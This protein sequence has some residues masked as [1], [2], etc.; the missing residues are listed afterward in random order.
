MRATSGAEALELL[1]ALAAAR[2]AGR[3]RRLRPADAGHDRHRA[4]RRRARRRAGREAAAAHGVRRHRR[5]DLGDQRHR[6]RLLPAQ[7]LGPAGGPALP[8]GRRPARATGATPTPSRASDVRV[9]GHRWSERQPRAS[10]PSSPATTCPTLARRRARRGGRRGC[11]TSP[12][13]SRTTCRSCSSRTARR[14]APRPRSSVADALGL[15]TRAERAALRPLHRRRRAGRARRR[16]LRRVRG[17]AAPSSSSATPRAGRPGRARRSRTTSA[18]P[19]GLSGADLAQRAIAQARRFGA[20]MVL[21]RDV[22]GLEARGPVRAVLPR[23]RRRHRGARASSSRPASPTGDSRPPGSTT[24]RA[25][26]STTAPTPSEAA[27]VPGRRG[28][29]RRRGQLR[30]PG[31]AQPRPV[32]QA[33]GAR[34]AAA[35]RLEATHVAVPRRAGPRPRRDR[36]AAAAPRWPVPTG[37][38]T[39]SA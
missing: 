6:A 14:C 24:S 33:G 18:S 23:R 28:L 39:S 17:A 8:R 26:A 11:G 35:T 32:R 10:R 12:A 15:R 30:R 3:P 27:P 25:R 2:P 7:A 9:V 38:A 5:R 37:T 36:G 13:P 31:G 34:R 21:A 16:G 1:A 20:E 29:R 22:V 4:A 19:S